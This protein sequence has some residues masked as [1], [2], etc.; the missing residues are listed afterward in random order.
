M[1]IPLSWPPVGARVALVSVGADNT[2]GHPTARTLGWLAGDGMRIDRT[3]REG[4]LAVVGPA[5][6]WGV[7]VRGRRR[8]PPARALGPGRAAAV[9]PRGTM[10]A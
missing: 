8:G 7:A 5:G 2:Y 4:D 10:A 1:P 3:D 9:S 6:P